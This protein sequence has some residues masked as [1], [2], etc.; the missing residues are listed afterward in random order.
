VAIRPPKYNSQGFTLIEMLVV[1]S[2][3]GIVA[4]FALPSLLALNKPLRDGTSQFKSAL[5]LIRMKAISSNQAYRIRPKY[6]TKA[7]YRGEKYQQKP[8]NFIVEYAANCQVDK[9]G[10]G[11]GKTGTTDPN[12]PPN[13]TYPNGLPDGWLRANQFDLDLPEAIGIDGTVK[14]ADTEITSTNPLSFTPA[15]GAS[16]TSVA[17]EANLN[18][19]ICYDNRGLAYQPVEL[20]FK[21]FQE[22]NRAK[23]STIQV[24]GI[25]QLNV[26]TKDNAGVIIPKSNGNS[27]F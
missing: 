27:V 11:V 19:N 7:E 2:I 18:W 13:T 10:Y 5:G 8:H 21:D 17:Y 16:A 14:V 12:R 15:N 23:T 20:T 22:N 3:V 1:I 25:G 6:L 24:T 26:D 9:Y 4:G